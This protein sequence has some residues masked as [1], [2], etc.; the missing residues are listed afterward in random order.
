MAHLWV[1]DGEGLW[2]I[3]PLEHR[4]YSVGIGADGVAELAVGEKPDSAVV[5]RHRTGDGRTSWILLAAEDQRVS[6]NG[7]SIV[8]GIRV[9]QDR[10]HIQL[11][12]HDTSISFFH[13]SE[14]IPRVDTFPGSDQQ[15]FCPRCKRV[16]NPGTPAVTCPGCGVWYHQS[17]EYPCWT[18]SDICATCPQKTDLEAAFEFSPEDL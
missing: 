6:V 9:L 2:C 15:V 18:Y 14:L 17:D 8:A 10:D 1:R 16:I 11:F 12:G 3:A 5:A 7:V 4:L 13:S